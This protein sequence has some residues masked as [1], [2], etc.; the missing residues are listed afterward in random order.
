LPARRPVATGPLPGLGEPLGML[1][2]IGGERAAN[3]DHLGERL[4]QALRR[5]NSLLVPLSIS[6]RLAALIGAPRIAAGVPNLFYAGTSTTTLEVWVI[7]QS[8]H[9]VSASCRPVVWRTTWQG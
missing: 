3:V 5:T 9:G 2:L 6:S 7:P 1:A 8:L 4:P